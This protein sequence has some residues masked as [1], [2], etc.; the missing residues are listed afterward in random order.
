[1]ISHRAAIVAIALACAPL[2]LPGCGGGAAS[3]PPPPGP[4]GATPTPV[5]T[6]TP[7]PAPTGP[8]VL[9]SHVV[10]IIQENR[11]VDNLFNGFPGADTVRQ[12]RN[13][14]GQMVTLAPVD[15]DVKW[16]V[17][18][19]YNAFVTEYNNG[20]MNGWDRATLACFISYCPPPVTAFAYV[21]P[22]EVAPYW[23]LAKQFA[24]AD[25]VLQTNE[26]SSFPAHQYLIAGQSGGGDSDHLAM[27]DSPDTPTG[28]CNINH[29]TIPTIDMTKPFPAVEGSP[30]FPCLDYNTI[31][32]EMT[33]KGLSWRYYTPTFNNIWAAPIAIQHI[34]FSSAAQNIV[35]PETQ[36]LSDVANHQLANLSYVV[37]ELSLSD[38]SG[39]STLQ[40][41]DWVG[42]VVNTIGSDPYYWK[43]TTVIVLWDDW[44][45][46][47]DHYATH[48][49]SDSPQN[50]YEYGFRVPLIA[51]SGYVKWAGYVDHTP[52]DM[53]ALLGFLEHVFGLPSL[54]QRDRSTD[55][56]FSM[57]DFNLLTPL[58]YKRVDT[59]GFTPST[60]RYRLT[61]TRTVDD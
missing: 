10:V 28:G 18:H 24:F 2:L 32:D 52:R 35:A 59:G 41:P 27:A 21:K 11:T 50:P 48:H 37:P 61:D 56:L 7:T 38:H 45:G 42:T 54:G 19:A 34:W 6:R 51:I 16:D 55:D 40:G 29:A 15:L 23:E 49:P 17:A 53:T 22:A 12:G 46:W 25:H 60:F 57:F 36:I 1:M 47:F 8:A 39:W 43:N 30:I 5:P 3:G 58:P 14:Q 44:G 13:S 9:P 20:A 26:G 31:L 4:S 33:A